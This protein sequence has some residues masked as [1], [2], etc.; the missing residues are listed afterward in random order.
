ME[1]VSTTDI[2]GRRI[3]YER[4]HPAREAAGRPTLVFLHEGL[5]SLAMWKDFPRRVVEAAACPALVYSRFGYGNSDGLLAPR[6]P[7]YMHREALEVLPALLDEFQIESPVLIGHSDGA[8]ISLIF[9]GSTRRPLAGIVVMAPHVMVE[10]ITIR[11]I[12]A[13]RNAYLKTNLRDKLGRHHADPDRAFRDWND[14]WLRPDFR[15]WNIEEYLPLIRCRVLAIQGECDEYGT[16]E[17]INII[18]RRASGVELLP[19]KDCGH[20]PHRDQP[21]T[22]IRAVSGF[23]ESLSCAGRP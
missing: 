6:D 5:G 15:A 19:L 21:L 23:I 13:A 12:A 10:G 2:L 9:G 8:S 16:L 18:A 3:E 7:L 14:I 20:A 4:L 22:V 17:Q 1:N 11:G